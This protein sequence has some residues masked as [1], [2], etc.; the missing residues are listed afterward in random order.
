MCAV[1]L[2][3]AGAC[4]ASDRNLYEQGLAAIADGI[5]QVGIQK[6]QN[7]LR[8]APD[9]QNE[10]VALLEITECLLE[11]DQPED[12]LKHLQNLN[13]AASNLLRAKA[14][15][16]LGLW[17]EALRVLQSI[18]ETENGS[19]E[20]QMLR[21][22]A[23]KELGRFVEAIAFLEKAAPDVMLQLQLADFYIAQGQ[24][25]KCLELLGRIKPESSTQVF[26]KRYAEAR[27]RLALGEYQE[28]LRTFDALLKEG[29][30]SSARLL[31]G[32][33]FGMAQTQLEREGAETA[34]DVVEAFISEN[35]TSPYL[36]KAFELLDS[37]YAVEEGAPN[38]ALEKWLSE[39]DGERAIQARF[40]L[41][42]ANVREQK[43]DRAQKLVRD[44]LQLYPGHPLTAEAG[45]LLGQIF[46]ASGEYQKA[47]TVF[48][49]AIRAASSAEVMA[50]VEMAAGATLFLQG[51]Y[52][53][54]TTHFLSARKHS[55]KIW[56]D[57]IFCSALAWLNQGNYEKFSED[58]KELSAKLPASSLR[59]EL[60][61]EEGL[62]QARTGNPQARQTLELFL[63]DFP[64]HA[65]RSDA[66]L[67][68]AEM[69]F[70]DS[71]SDPKPAGDYLKIVNQTVR[72]PQTAEHAAYLQ[73]NLA[74][75]RGGE[76]QKTAVLL[77]RKFLQDYPRSN[78]APEV[79]MKM[80]Q[81]YFKAEDYANAETEFSLLANENPGSELRE[82]ALFLAGQSA[83]R[84][85]S[86]GAAERALDLFEET[87]KLGGPLK[88][89]A[90]EAQAIVQLRLGKEQ[91]A[92]T[93]YDSI[94]Q[95]EPE[96]EL[97]ASVLCGK[98][99]VLMGLGE[100]TPQMLQKAAA[101]YTQ[102]AELPDVGPHW[103]NQASYKLGKCL[104]KQGN[105]PEALT[106]FYDV[107][108]GAEDSRQ[109][110]YFWFYKA[111]F[112]AALM[113]EE[114]KQWN[115]AVGVYQKIANI[116][117][118]RAEEAKERIRQLRLEHFLWED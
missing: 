96:T 75:V 90:L 39:K 43:I 66:L 78:L 71:E 85:L 50:R 33:A 86:A 111:G 92:L 102:L 56:E 82:S 67:A 27:V 13:S 42:K 53:L 5:P 11:N 87:V 83:L 10:A 35:P 57:A 20:Y 9:P 112:T 29:K 103:R 1:L 108:Q 77:G 94:L 18:P 97:R 60:L 14:L 28:A 110:E 7:Y 32:A 12:A 41:A 104:E 8:Q 101:A 45:L 19:V 95:A 31:A 49:A 88:L 74:E 24:S 113:L 115:S 118:P 46:S 62:H 98:G 93:I 73:F 34:D 37:L 40:Y 105:Q 22:C 91:E 48:E 117:G 84:S 36:G 38:A 89:N 65:R 26:L 16:R 64:A 68:M 114:Q 81:I 70:L 58:Y 76:D 3:M 44:F 79:R 107:L 47:L 23:L 54:A 51:E 63:Q 25:Q 80:A 21:A 69:A 6:L 59:S 2:G 4:A 99:D 109:P 100:K 30:N 106:A 116:Q 17:E 61:L 72:S 52:V 15:G 55:E